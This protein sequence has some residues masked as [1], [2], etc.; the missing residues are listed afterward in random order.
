M[1]DGLIG[2]PWGVDI[3]ISRSNSTQTPPGAAQECTPGERG[4]IWVNTPALMKGYLGRDDL[5]RQVVSEGWFLTGDIGFIDEQGLLYLRG[6]ER[7]EIN[8]GGT[9][10][11]PA[12]ID[13]VVERFD[14]TLDVCSFG[15]KD[16]LY[17]ENVGIAVVLR[18][19]NEESLRRLY[20][21][22]SRHLA[23]HQL[24]LRWHIVEEIPRT[25]RGKVNRARMA[26][27]CA[28]LSP[29]DPRDFLRRG[30]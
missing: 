29:I 6:R 23:K 8:K 24:P 4:Y 10:V 30:S 21:W 1:E 26:E 17:G 14:G 15:Y 5:T 9:K 19:S 16:P 25:S 27:R 28:Q 7:E 13:A 11:Y 22:A 3:K 18:S 2:V 20:D 12:D